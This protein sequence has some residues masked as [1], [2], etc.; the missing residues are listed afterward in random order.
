MAFPS[1]STTAGPIQP[2]ETS[3]LCSCSQVDELRTAVTVLAV[4]LATS[5]ATALAFI[6]Y[7]SKRWQ[8]K[9]AASRQAELDEIKT[10]NKQL[11]EKIES[12]NWHRFFRDPNNNPIHIH[13]RAPS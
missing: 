5:I 4:V 9:G 6:I 1:T 8:K 13:N 3:G 11:E 7:R 2:T 10:K 12:M